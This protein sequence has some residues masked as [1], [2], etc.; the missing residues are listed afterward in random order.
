VTFLDLTMTIMRLNYLHTYGMTSFFTNVPTFRAILF[1]LLSFSFNTLNAQICNNLTDGGTISGDES[2]CNSPIFDP[3]PILST[4][5]ASGGTGDIEY[6]WMKTTGDPNSPFNTWQIIPGA[7]GATYDPIPITQT[8][9]YGR[10]SRRSGCTEYI[11]ETNFVVKTISCC[12]INPVIT[13]SNSAICIKEP[14]VLSVTG[15]GTGFTYL[16]E[17]TGGTFDNPTSSNPTYMMMMPGTYTIKVTI[18]MGTCMEMAETTVIVENQLPV[19]ITAANNS[20]GVNQFLQLNSTVSGTNPTYLWSVSGGTL[21]NPTASNPTYTSPTEGDFQIYLTAIDENGCT[22][23][24]TFDIKVGGCDLFLLGIAEDLSCSGFTDG[25]ITLTTTGAT[26]T[27][28]YVWGQSGIGNTNNPLNLAAGTYTVTATDSEGCSANTTIEVGSPTPLIVSPDI[29]LPNC[30]GDNSGQISVTVTGGSP[31]Y[32][33]NWSNG[34]PN[35]AFVNNLVA[36]TYSLT[37]TDAN[38]CQAIDSYQVGNP[39]ALTLTTN[40]TDAACNMNNGTATVSATGGATPYTYAW[41]DPA[42]QTTATAVNLAGGTYQ[43]IVTD[44]N[45]CQNNASITI[46]SPANNIVVT[47]ISTDASCSVN[48][49]TATVATVTGGTPPYSY[50][51]NDPANQTT[52]TAT[53]LPAG[54]YQVIATDANGCQSSASV[55]INAPIN[56]LV[57]TTNATAPTSCELTDGTATV[58]VSGGTAPYTYAWNDS[59]NQTTAT[60]TNLASGTYQVIVTDQNGCQS[61]ETVTVNPSANTTIVLTVTTTNATCGN[62]NGTADLTISGGTAPYTILWDNGIGNVEDPINLAAGVYTVLVTDA[63][64]CSNSTTVIIGEEGAINVSLDITNISCN[65]GSDGTITTTPSGGTA[66][67][68]YAWSNGING[69]PTITGLIAGVYTVTITDANGCQNVASATLLDP[70]PLTI[71]AAPNGTDC[72][73]PNGSAIAMVSGG[74]P[75]YTFQWNDANNQTTQSVVNLP[76]GDYTVVVTDANGC[77]AS[78]TTTIDPSMG[79]VVT[80]TTTDIFCNGDNSGSIMANVAN[81]TAPFS[82]TWNNFLPDFPGFTGLAQGTYEVTVTDAN[83]CF[84]T[85]AAKVHSIDSLI[86]TPVVENAGCDAD[87][88]R[89]RLD[90]RGGTSPYTYAWDPPINATTAIVTNLA[91]GGYSFTVTDANGC[92]YSDAIAVLRE[93]DCD[94]MG[95]CAVVGGVISSTDPLII[96]AG[97]GIPD[98]ITVAL[99]GNMGSNTSWIVTDEALNIIELPNSNVFNFDGAGFGTCYIWSVSYE[100]PINGLVI[101]QNAA[102]ITGCHQLSNNLVVVRQDCDTME[103]CTITPGSIT[104]NDP[105]VFCVGDGNADNVNIN[106]TNGTGALSSFIITDIE[107]NILDISTET[108]YNFENTP[109]RIC[110]I[111]NITYEAGLTGLTIGSSMDDLAGCFRL[112]NVLTIVKQDCPPEDCVDFNGSISINNPAGPDICAKAEVRLST[113]PARSGFTYNWTATGGNFDDNTSA[114]PTYSMMMPGTYQILVTVTEGMC[115]TTDSTMITILSGPEVTLAS[116]DAS[117]QGVND[118]SITTSITGGTAPYTYAW[119]DN[120]IGNTPNPTNLAPGTYDLTLTD[121]NGCATTGSTTINEGS[122]ITLTLTPT[123]LVCSGINQGSINTTVNGGIA[124]FTYTWSDNTIGNIPNPTNLPAGTYELTL[125]DAN[126]CSATNSTTI[127]DGVVINVNLTPANSVCGGMDEGSITSTVNGGTAPYTYNWS[128]G[129]T[130]ENISNLAAG[131]YEVTVTDAN[132][133]QETANATVN[134]G[135]NIN[136]TLTPSNPSCAGGNDGSISSVISGGTAPFAYNWSNGVTTESLSNLVAGIYSLTITDDNGCMVIATATVEEGATIDIILTPS[137]PLCAGAN[138]GSISSSVSGGTAPYTYNWSNGTTGVP[139][140]TNLLAGDYTL[141]VTDANGCMAIESTTINDGAI[142]TVNIAVTNPVCAGT[143]EGS[144]TASPSGGTAPY[145]YNWSDGGSTATISNLA[146]GTYEVTVTDDNGCSTTASASITAPASFEVSIISTPRDICPGGSVNFGAAPA[147][148]T[149]TY[150]WTATGGSFDDDTSADPIYTM[151]MPGIYEIIVVISNGTCTA[152][153]TTFVTIGEG[154]DFTIDQTDITCVGETDGSITVTVNNGVAPITYT[155]DNGIPNIPNPTGLAAGTYNLTI[156]D[157]NNCERTASVTIN[158]A[159]PIVIGFVETNILCGGENT[160]SIDA[161]V[162]GGTS[163]LFLAWSTGANNVASIN[164]LSAGTYALTVTDA[165]GCMSIGVVTINEP[166]A[167]LAGE[168]LNFPACN[169][170]DGSITL[171]PSGGTGPYTFLWTTP[172][173]PPGMQPT[174][175]AL[176]NL[177]AGTYT[178]EIT[179]ALGCSRIFPFALSNSNAPVPNTAT[180]D[181]TCFGENDGEITSMPTG[182]TPPYAYF[183]SPNGET[184]ISISGLTAGL[185]SLNVTDAMGCIGVAVDTIIQPEVL[186]GNINATNILCNGVCDGTA[187]SNTVGGTPPYSYSWSPGNLTQDSIFD[188]CAGTYVLTVTD[189]NG[190]NTPTITESIDI[191]EPI[192]ITASFNVTDA[193]CSSTCDGETTVSL[194]G[195]TPPYNFQWN[196]NTAPGQTDTETGLCFGANSFIAIDQN[197][198]TNMFTFNVGAIDT[199]IADAGRDSSI[200]LGETYILRGSSSNNVSSVEWFELPSFNSLG[201]TDTIAITPTVAD[202]FLYVFQANG[203]CSAFDTVSIIVHPLPIVEAGDDVSIVEN[204]NTELQATG[205]SVSYSWSPGIS[206]TDSTIANPISSPLITTEYFV[207]GTSQYGCIAID[208]VTVTILPRITFPDGITPNGDGKNDFWVIDLIEEFPNNVVEIYNRW[209]QLLFRA[210]GYQ[211]DWGGTHNGKDLPIG[212]YYY[213]VDLNEP[214]LEPISGPITILR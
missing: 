189:A 208:S 176:T 139:T 19:A 131:V 59:V 29:K 74:T 8:T 61:S 185:Y 66:P 32:T 164:N 55:T 171:N 104:T 112:S 65:G 122:V 155:W 27:V 22:G 167:I 199:V 195:G 110:L 53:N 128:N 7:N 206:L 79:L 150:Q 133:C 143:N 193:A 50:A 212:T 16:W 134:D 211:Q 78:A 183:W 201:T 24:D 64:G 88:G 203:P 30:V 38:G 31:N 120:T 86:V 15:N 11:G 43:V 3:S 138:D 97:D 151:M 96:C 100:N 179:D 54:T 119:S 136:I 90:V 12:D 142:I 184:T 39:T 2:G 160:G 162:L 69:T 117:C 92:T 165:N 214:G 205:N 147:D 45:G 68:S 135:A 4:A 17:A 91:P 6:I 73:N 109:A 210:E 42:N 13:P 75:G 41:N 126:G 33:Y 159:D 46:N 125:T 44:A 130:T 102:N 124:P 141:T 94:T 95:T 173:A 85:A 98:N 18:T 70:D 67:Y 5:A 187:V 89:A 190:C 174:T 178:V 177:G 40:A 200:C 72:V 105:L 169:A 23:I 180:Q 154:I 166:I 20:I 87:D 156:T 108:S 181:V 35:A 115:V 149:L 186:Q 118:G 204:G 58:T 137:S 10:C 194:T 140:L 153:D 158:D 113:T 25:S 60:A 168:V 34:L 209:G 82:Y 52:A 63:V 83:G 81:G 106:L 161:L 127:N 48:N 49:G 107:S 56:N 129:A 28:S 9:Y 202:T 26:G 163:P 123:P 77:T 84:G 36:G 93:T 1:L 145:T 196:G 114:T 37:V 111:W 99:T 71:S 198:C 172:T 76:P 47:A 14:L 197:G 103:T 213:L 101:G 191:L 57:L 146:A 80:L 170:N 192:A 157:G 132:G 116:S 121:V 148:P 21:S 188:L 152:T 144:L 207:T 175:A 51:W 182:G 62:A